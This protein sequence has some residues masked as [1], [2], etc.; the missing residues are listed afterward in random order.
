MLRLTVLPI[1]Q[2][3]NFTPNEGWSEGVLAYSE[4]GLN[5]TLDNGDFLTGTL[6]DNCSNI[7][8]D[9]GSSFK[10]FTEPMS[11]LWQGWYSGSAV[12][13]E[14]Y[15]VTFNGSEL[16]AICDTTYGSCGWSAGTGSIIG[17]RVSLSLGDND[18]LTG[19]ISPN[20]SLIIWDNN[21]LWGRASSQLLPQ[22]IRSVHVVFMNH[23]DVGYNGI[24][25]TGFINNILNIYFHQYFP[26]AISI[27]Q[28]MRELGGTDRFIY[29][30]HPWLVSMYLD[31][32]PN[33]NLSG[34]VLQCPDSS[35]VRLRAHANITDKFFLGIPISVVVC[36]VQ[37]RSH[38]CAIVF[39][40]L[41]RWLLLRLRCCEAI[42]FGM[43]VPSIYNRR[44]WSQACSQLR[45]DS[46][47][48]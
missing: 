9:N 11:G 3:T 18:E 17:D 31:C 27:A 20:M 42:L 13:P 26:R 8:W 34:I 6:T 5:V 40:Q 28:Q 39:M 45:S 10:K 35:D 15:V 30:T 25:L 33:L 43:P 14:V 36:L 22:P 19:T 38:V 37:A 7:N 32:P 16:A 41:C 24:P 21:S 12:L 47:Q 44:I 2:V 23:L 1:L 29:T 46:P 4:D 48:T